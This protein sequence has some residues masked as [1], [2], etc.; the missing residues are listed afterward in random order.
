MHATTDPAARREE[1]NKAFILYETAYTN[2]KDGTLPAFLAI[3]A[4]ESGRMEEAETYA[5]V[6][7]RGGV[8]GSWTAAKQIL[9]RI[10]VH[11]DEFDVAE[12]NLM[13]SAEPYGENHLGVGGPPFELAADLMKA[14]RRDAVLH[15]LD[16]CRACTWP[17][18]KKID[19]WET[20]VK[21]GRV[22]A[23][24]RNYPSN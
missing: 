22:P 23:E 4:Y 8:V 13:E 9:G 14:G 10:A 18:R 15:Y 5:H 7:S 6:A 21:A 3:T 2:R 1:A 12:Q 19:R 16:R 24:W 20:E 17:G 11:R